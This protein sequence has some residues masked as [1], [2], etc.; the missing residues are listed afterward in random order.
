MWAYIPYMDNTWILWVYIY[1]CIYSSRTSRFHLWPSS[2]SE[3]SCHQ[4][5]ARMALLDI[6]HWSLC[7]GLDCHSIS[8][9]WWLSHLPLWKMMEWTSVGMIFHSQPPWKI[10]VRQWEGLSHILW[11]KL[12]TSKPP[13]SPCLG[14][15]WHFSATLGPL[16]PRDSQNRRTRCSTPCRC[17]PLRPSGPEGFR[18]LEPEAAKPQAKPWEKQHWVLQNGIPKM[19]NYPLVI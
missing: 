19:E 18:V 1:I 16:G 9:G 12:K 5:S 2:C 4:A 14:Q 13:S 8:S 7:R 6:N 11:K 15:I 10:W 3:V 17:R